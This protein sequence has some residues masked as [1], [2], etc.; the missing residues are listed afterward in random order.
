[1]KTVRRWRISSIFEIGRMG[2]FLEVQ[3]R[4]EQGCGERE[5]SNQRRSGLKTDEFVLEGGGGGG[6]AVWAWC[7]A[8]SRGGA[9]RAGVG[10][11]VGRCVARGGGGGGGGVGGGGAGGGGAGWGGGDGR[12]RPRRESPRLHLDEMRGTCRDSPA[13]EGRRRGRGGILARRLVIS[14]SKT[15]SSRVHRG[16]AGDPTK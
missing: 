14:R 8:G 5:R 7:V 12:C 16:A 10:G 4:R 6:G 15:S 3:W 13:V 1:M 9:G 11:V 2:R